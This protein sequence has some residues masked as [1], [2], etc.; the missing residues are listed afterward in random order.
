MR[1]NTNMKEKFDFFKLSERETKKVTGG[2]M[3]CP[4][5]CAYANCGGSSFS[6]NSGANNEE[7]LISIHW[8]PQC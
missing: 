7:G 2:A 8:T 5:S 3:F 1:R 6:D 4:C